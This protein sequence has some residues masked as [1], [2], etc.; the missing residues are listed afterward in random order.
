MSV[1]IILGSANGYM[2]AGSG[3]RKP[4]MSC[5]LSGARWRGRAIQL[6][7]R[8]SHS[9]ALLFCVRLISSSLRSH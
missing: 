9:L 7:A 6:L 2:V 3:R 4:S 1:S 8:M 5:Q